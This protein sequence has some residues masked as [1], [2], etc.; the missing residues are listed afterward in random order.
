MLDQLP[1]EDLSTYLVR[2]AIRRDI[3]EYFEDQKL[4][5]SSIDEVMRFFK[6]HGIATGIE[7]VVDR[8]FSPK[9]RLAKERD[10]TRF[11]DGTFPVLYGAI[12]VQTAEAEVENWFRKHVGTHARTAFYVC[13]GYR[14]RGK[15]KDLRP[16]KT[17]WPALTNDKDYRF[18]NELGAEAVATSLDGL[19][20][21][22]V[23]NDGGTNLPA[24]A[25]RAVDEFSEGRFVALTYDPASGETTLREV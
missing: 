4:D 22:S 10:R 1:T 12:E 17:E 14:F 20:A 24:F 11:S 21:P 3:K 9:R 7:D 23:R 2:L 18:C 25:R 13:I 5:E 6:A 8:M 15:V 16:K 19:L